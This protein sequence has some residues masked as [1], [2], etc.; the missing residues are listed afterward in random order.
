MTEERASVVVVVREDSLLGKRANVNGSGGP[1]GCVVIG[2]Q[3]ALFGSPAALRRLAAVTND[4]AASVERR[5]GTGELLGDPG[6]SV[7]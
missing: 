5:C 6:G 2:S 4:A 3:L 7:A 1:R